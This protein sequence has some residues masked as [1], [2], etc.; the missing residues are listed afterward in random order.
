MASDHGQ[1]PWCLHFRVKVGLILW[2]FMILSQSCVEPAVEPIVE[3]SALL[4]GYYCFHL[5][6]NLEM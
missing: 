1:V 5:N 3:E 6:R 2:G 4:D